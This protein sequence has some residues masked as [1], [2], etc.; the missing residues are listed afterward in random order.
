[1]KTVNDLEKWASSFRDDKSLGAVAMSWVHMKAMAD[2]IRGAKLNNPGDIGE[3]RSYIAGM[4][5]LAIY[6]GRRFVR[7]WSEEDFR[8]LLD[9]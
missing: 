4:M 2:F 6:L 5:V 7:D 9:E 8:V 1:M 3:N